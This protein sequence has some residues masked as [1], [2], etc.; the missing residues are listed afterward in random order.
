ME[1]KTKLKLATIFSIGGII[2]SIVSLF[3]TIMRKLGYLG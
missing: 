2:L 1:I 3:I